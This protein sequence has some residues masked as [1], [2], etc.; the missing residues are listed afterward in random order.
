MKVLLHVC[1]GICATA[2][3]ERLM[4]EGHRVTGYF[5]NPNIHPVDEYKKRLEAAKKAAE[6]LGFELVEGPYDRERWFELVKG[7]E[8]EVEGG[9]RCEICYK[10][11]LEKTYEYM[12]KKM[13]DAFTTTLSASPHKDAMLINAI[14]REIG[15]ERFICADFKKKGGFA[16][17]TELSDEM[18]LY[19]Q[20]YCGCIYSQEAEHR[21]AL[22]HEK[23]NHN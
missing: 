19:R 14:G 10:M 7:T 6:E 23:E 9:S 15:D 3:A 8:Y 12:R 16:R 11:R 5:Y 13:F 22:R 1:C 18:A 2:V 20:H 17:A 4:C 21:K